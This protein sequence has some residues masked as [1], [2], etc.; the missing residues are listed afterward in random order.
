MIRTYPNEQTIIYT[1]DE[2]DGFLTNVYLIDKPSAYYVIDTFLG[3]DAMTFVKEDISDTSK[4]V[5]VINTHFHWD[6]IWGNCAFEGSDIIAHRLC[7]AHIKESFDDMTKTKQA[8]LMG[9]VT[10]TLPNRHIDRDLI[11][12]DGIEIYYTPGHTN[13]SISVY[14]QLNN[15][16]IVGDNLELPLIYLE[17]FDI[18]AYIHSLE[19]YKTLEC[20]VI[21]AS[22]TTVIAM[23]A[24]D[25]TLLYLKMLKL[26][27]D[28]SFVDKK[29][30]EIHGSN[31]KILRS[32]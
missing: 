5:V 13:D 24:L 8:Y 10:L 15:L 3:P 17:S 18:D 27:K 21:T 9:D 12:G 28:M 30:M 20:E 14:D 22:H 1:F 7:N 31:L 32:L 19:F 25:E 4:E 26:G 11:L 29:M 2:L 23:E 16:L 6:H